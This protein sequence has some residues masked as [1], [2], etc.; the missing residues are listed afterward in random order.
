M[1]F[2][3][4]IPQGFLLARLGRLIQVEEVCFQSGLESVNEINNDNNS[5]Y[6][7]LYPVNIYELMALYIINMRIHLT[8]EKNVKRPRRSIEMQDITCPKDQRELMALKQMQEAVVYEIQA[9]AHV[10]VHMLYAG[11]ELVF[12]LCSIFNTADNSDVTTAK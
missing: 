3:H 9:P 4:T 6:I 10:Y 11:C 1:S 7:A 5:S 8:I 2:F 12:Y